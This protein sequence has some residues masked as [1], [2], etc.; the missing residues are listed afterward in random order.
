MIVVVVVVV[1]KIKIKA[2]KINFNSEE[3]SVPSACKKRTSFP[4][5]LMGYAK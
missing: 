2:L 1:E 5:R 3:H 4:T